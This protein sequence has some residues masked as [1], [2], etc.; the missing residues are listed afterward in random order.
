MKLGKDYIITYIC[1]DDHG[2]GIRLQAQRLIFHE[3]KLG[4]KPDQLDYRNNLFDY[5]FLLIDM[6]SFP[7]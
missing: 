3:L 2:N 4:K 6:L 5:Y 1:K 7:S